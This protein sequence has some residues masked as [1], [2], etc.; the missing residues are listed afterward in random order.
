[1]AQVLLITQFV[2]IIGMLAIAM[3]KWDYARR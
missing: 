1:M 3:F 2:G